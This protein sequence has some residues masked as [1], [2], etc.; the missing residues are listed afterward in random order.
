VS[1]RIVDLGGGSG[2]LIERCLDRFPS[3]KATV[4]DQSEAFLA[5]AE[6]RL[7]KFGE[8]AAVELCRLQDWRA[9]FDCPAAIVSMS[10][11]HHLTPEEKQA[12]YRR[13]FEALVH[14]G[15]F[16]N[17][18]EVRPAGDAD[19]LRELTAWW[20]HMDAGLASGAIP[21]AMRPIL[22][23]WRERNIDRFEAPRKSGD[24]CHEPVEQQLDYLR[25]AGFE[26]VAAPWRREM[27]AIMMG[28]T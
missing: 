26:S 15:L 10:A 23:S 4:V 6:R 12:F 19:Y 14:G 21:A 5:V 7:A 2:R 28:R 3:A 8:R 22:E 27:W 1:R 11:I 20:Q 25:E 18:D 9:K 16:I 24:D 13:C 17:A